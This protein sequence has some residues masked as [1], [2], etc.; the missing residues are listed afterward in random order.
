[1]GRILPL[2]FLLAAGQLAWAGQTIR[3]RGKDF[4]FSVREPD[5]W[6]I[7]FLSARQIANFVMHQK[8]VP[9]RQA[10]VIA[11]GRLIQ[12]SDQEDIQ[13]VI[14]K[15]LEEF[16]RTCPHYE[17]EEI[18]IGTSGAHE[19]LFK[20]YHC[21]GIRSEIIATTEVTGY[22]VRFILSSKQP[23]NVRKA[24]SSFQELISSFLWSDYPVSK[25]I[26]EP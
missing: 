17:V 11:L 6:S 23:E 10:D 25:S 19:F 22:F 24:L 13:G 8:G 15:D 20:S 18:D 16:R 12:R 21:P 2:V 26:L 14:E 1:M 3:L 7:D 4:S 5:G 9:W